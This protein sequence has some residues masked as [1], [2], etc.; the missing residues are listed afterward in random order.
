MYWYITK[1]F[2]VNITR[3]KIIVIFHTFI[4]NSPRKIIENTL[5]SYKRHLSEIVSLGS[6]LSHEVIFMAFSKMTGLYSV[7]LTDTLPSLDHTNLY[8]TGSSVLF[9]PFHQQLPLFLCNVLVDIYPV[10]FEG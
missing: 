6:S 1:I 2:T 7:F 5:V 10:R 3:I 9:T 4:K 8:C